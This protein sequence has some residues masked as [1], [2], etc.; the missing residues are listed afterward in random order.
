MV[1]VQI[2]TIPSTINTHTT[3]P[4]QPSVQSQGV[5]EVSTLPTTDDTVH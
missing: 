4:S 5:E 3:E 1:P 2:G